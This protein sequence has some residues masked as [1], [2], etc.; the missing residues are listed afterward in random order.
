MSTDVHTENSWAQTNMK[1]LGYRLIRLDSGAESNSVSNSD[2]RVELTRDSSFRR[3]LCDSA[4]SE[5]NLVSSSGRSAWPL[6]L[7]SPEKIQPCEPARDRPARNWRQQKTPETNCLSPSIAVVPA[8]GNCSPTGAAPAALLVRS[9]VSVFPLCPRRPSSSSKIFSQ[10]AARPKSGSENQQDTNAENLQLKAQI[11][12]V[13][14]CKSV[15][16]SR[17]NGRFEV[18]RFSPRTP[19][20]FGLVSPVQTAF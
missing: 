8:A 6:G 13:E 19:N 12:T 7:Q 9:V 3:S 20:A 16:N 17:A 1:E 10:E 5:E 4:L 15:H 14:L 18:G 2:S 11:R